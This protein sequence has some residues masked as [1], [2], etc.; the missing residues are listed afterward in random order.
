[1]GY[2]VEAQGRQ[3]GSNLNVWLVFKDGEQHPVGRVEKFTDTRSTK[4]PWKAFVRS[5]AVYGGVPSLD[6]LIGFCYKDVRL[7][8]HD[9]GVAP[10]FH[11]DLTRAVALIQ[12][13]G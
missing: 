9:G 2:R 7:T 11:G 6:K 12:E 3:H 8:Q 10:Y 4:N 1:M 5:G 13:H